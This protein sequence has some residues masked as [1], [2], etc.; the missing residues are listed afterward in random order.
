M[1]KKTA[2][3]LIASIVLVAVLCVFIFA[4]QTEYMNRKGAETISEI[5]E[6]YMSGLS[7]RAAAHFQTTVELR[8]S[9]VSALVDSV[10][11]DSS[12][13]DRSI[14]V[15]LNYHA[16]AR[17]FDHLAFYGADGTFDMLYGDLVE[18]SGKDGFFHSLT[19]GEEKMAVGYDSTGEEV[20][21]MCVPGSSI[22]TG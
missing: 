19:K 9:Q 22:V 2:R 4:Y 10:S 13:S 8:M 16:R 18:V 3:F 1:N 17:G 11:P 15:S 7:E 5:G 20:L 21:T 14:R 12:A 6:I